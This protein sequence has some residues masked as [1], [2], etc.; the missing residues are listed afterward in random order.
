MD[1]DKEEIIIGSIVFGCATYGIINI[2]LNTILAV[3]KVFK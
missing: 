1:F 3:I 2:V